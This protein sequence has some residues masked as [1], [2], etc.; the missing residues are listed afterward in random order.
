MA[1]LLE[2]LP[3]I[4]FFVIYKTVDI[5]WATG[6]LIVAAL[7]QLV[8]YKVSQGKIEKRH[9]IFAGV[10]LVLGG[11]TLVFHDEQF[12]QWK[13]TI[14]YALLGSALVISQLLFKT[15]LVQKALMGIL[16]SVQEEQKVTIDI[17]SSVF[18]QLLIFWAILL[19]GIA[20]LNLYVAY[21]YSLDVW[22]NFKVFGLMGITFVA[23]LL[24]MFKIYKYLPE[25]K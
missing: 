18:N 21:H 17:P 2:Y 1:L 16:S 15:N 6:V 5:F 10:A 3:L 13:A 24:T 7:V 20:A 25:E 23:I 4:L 9:W 19:Y 11:M 14:I 12:I 22:V 8:Y